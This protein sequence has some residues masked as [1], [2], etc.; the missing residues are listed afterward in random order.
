MQS[1]CI[2]KKTK[3]KPTNQVDSLSSFPDRQS[4]SVSGK[5]GKSRGSVSGGQ[6]TRRGGG[7]E[8]EGEEEIS[9]K[10]L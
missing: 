3:A 1:G 6:L 2:Y 5:L 7:E 9:A 4:Q 8:E 10:I